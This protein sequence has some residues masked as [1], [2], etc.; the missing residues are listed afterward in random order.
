MY[1]LPYLD[2]FRQIIELPYY[3]SANKHIPFDFCQLN[4][5]K[6]VPKFAPREF[7]PRGIDPSTIWLPN[8][9]ISED[10]IRQKN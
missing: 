8:K 6:N 3:H 10:I 1:F 2:L 4:S 9:G 5:Q 7:C